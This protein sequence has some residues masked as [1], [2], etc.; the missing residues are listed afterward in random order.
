MGNWVESAVE[1]AAD[2]GASTR[3]KLDE[4]QL[5]VRIARVIGVAARDAQIAEGRACA[6]MLVLCEVFQVDCYGRADDLLVCCGPGHRPAVHRKSAVGRSGR[7]L[8]NYRAHRA[9]SWLSAGRPPGGLS[10]NPTY[11]FL[12]GSR[13][14]P[15]AFSIAIDGAGKH[16]RRSVLQDTIG[17]SD[18]PQLPRV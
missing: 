17:E 15:Q 12:A 3:L 1:S 16:L 2:P 5:I 14:G 6:E 8:Q 4:V 18:A 10:R 7:E 13:S 9:L 11:R